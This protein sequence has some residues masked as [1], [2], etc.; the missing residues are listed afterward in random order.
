MMK[1]IWALPMHKNQ[2]D[3]KE[4]SISKIHRRCVIDQNGDRQKEEQEY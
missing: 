1:C 2:A 4:D 3:N